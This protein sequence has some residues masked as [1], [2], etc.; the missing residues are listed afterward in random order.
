M[1]RR[2]ITDKLPVSRSLALLV[3]NRRKEL[4]LTVSAL[5]EEI[6]VTAEVLRKAL[7][8]VGTLKVEVFGR[9]CDTLGVCE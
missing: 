6:G 5:A 4:K 7:H 9:M 8:G 1:N 3:E 2:I